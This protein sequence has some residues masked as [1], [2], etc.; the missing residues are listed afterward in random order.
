MKHRIS[1]ILTILF[2][3]SFS[4]KAQLGVYCDHHSITGLSWSPDGNRLAVMTLH[5]VFIYDHDLNVIRSIEAP[6]IGYEWLTPNEP[7]WSPDGV[8]IILPEHSSPAGAAENRETWIIANSETA[9]LHGIQLG[10]SRYEEIVWSPDNELILG[11]RYEPA[12]GLR[13]PYTELVISLGISDYGMSPIVKRY[14]GMYLSNI[15][16][17]ENGITARTSGLSLAFDSQLNLI[18]EETM[19][20]ASW[21]VSNSDETRQAAQKPD[22]NFYVQ[23]IGLEEQIV[24]ISAFSNEDGEFISI[25]FVDDIVWLSDNQSLIGIFKRDVPHLYAEYPDLPRLLQGTVVDAVAAVE[26]DYFVIELES[27]I[28]D[29]SVSVRGDRIALVRD[30]TWLE[31][32]NPLDEERL[33]MID[34]PPLPIGDT[35]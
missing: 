25:P 24:I 4:A 2:F 1:L 11:L 10:F 17:D 16:W 22:Y 19:A 21:W 14:E 7:I 32:W 30:D 29:Y 9:E 28:Q 27:N 33:T 26:T 13:F 15:A 31:L 35:C 12:M 18:P 8:W 23:E 3:F 6:K 34:V 20:L 5:G